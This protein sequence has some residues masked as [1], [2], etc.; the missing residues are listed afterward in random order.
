MILGVP[1]GGLGYSAGSRDVQRVQY[2]LRNLAAFTSDPMLQVVPDGRIGPK[3]RAAANRALRLYAESAPPG[4]RSGFL[5][6]RQIVR[7]APTIAHA[8]E[9]E[10]PL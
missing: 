5:S 1:V 9:T 4:L 8:L 7:H 3:T 10:A 6:T 2:A